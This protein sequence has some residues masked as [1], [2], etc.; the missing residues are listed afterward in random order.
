[1]DPHAAIRLIHI[2]IGVDRHDDAFGW[3]QMS[4]AIKSIVS[5][6]V[7]VRNGRALAELLTHRRSML[8]EVRE[9]SGINAAHSID[10]VQSEIEVIEAG[11]EELK[12]PARSLP[13]KRMALSRAQPSR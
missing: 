8:T 11:L 12:P 2:F 3:M 10:T 7:K 6:Y 13:R 9:I 1:M 4:Q 5:G